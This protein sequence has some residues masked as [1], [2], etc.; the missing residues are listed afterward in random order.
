[1]RRPLPLLALPLLAVA[2]ADYVMPPGATPDAARADAGDASADAFRP[3]PV[4]VTCT[5]HYGVTI[6]EGRYVPTELNPAVRE[7]RTGSGGTGEAARHFF[8]YPVGVSHNDKLLLYLVGTTDSPTQYI[9]FPRR[10]CALGYAAVSIAYHNEVDSRSTCTSNSA[11]YENFRREIV[12]GMDALPDPIHVTQADSIL[13]RFL[14]VL[15]TL[16]RREVYFPAWRAIR[17]RVAARDFSRVA[18]AGHS[19]GSGHA[20]FIARDFEVERL[21][22]LAG[23][24]DRMNSGFA[25]NAAPA[26]IA[27][28]NFATAQTPSTRFFTY[29]HDDDGVAVV[30]QVLDNWNL[31]RVPAT[32]CPFTVMAG[33][34]PPGCHRIRVP[35]AR[36]GGGEAHNMVMVGAFGNSTNACL[37]SGTASS[38]DVTFRH[39]LTAAT[40]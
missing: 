1:M 11:C 12:Y 18:V 34:Y 14:N 15:E 28:W 10:A 29:M 40:E 37:L 6:C 3:I 16:E 31:L 13:G 7:V 33:A 27:N 38:N 17:A 20:L 25:A 36:C 2:C 9:E 4:N 8:C 39:M 21:I 26:W 30:R 24:T 35:A 19:Q 32:E 23:V 5:V 22:M